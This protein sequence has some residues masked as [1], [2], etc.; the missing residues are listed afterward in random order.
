MSESLIISEL[1]DKVKTLRRKYKRCCCGTDIAY[2]DIPHFLT[3]IVRD[4][5]E[6]YRVTNGL[7]D[8]DNPPKP[9][10]VQELDITEATPFDTLKYNNIFGTKER[11][12][13]I[14]GLQTYGDGILVD[15]LYK[16][17][18]THVSQD[19]LN[20]DDSIDAAV[21]S[22]IGGF[23]DWFLLTRHEIWTLFDKQTD[24]SVI[25]PIT[26]VHLQKTGTPRIGSTQHY[27][28]GLTF[29]TTVGITSATMASTVPTPIGVRIFDESDLNI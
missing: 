9:K 11:F 23:D 15:H 29:P 21:N 4:G 16:R 26:L 10:Y 2:Q 22:T 7:M 14:N 27:S 6:G 17:M 19:A 28:F 5:D 18:Y 20:W 12:T 24:P 13:D 25:G 3:T 8:L 1:E